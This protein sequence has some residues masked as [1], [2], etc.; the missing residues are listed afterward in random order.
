MV[1]RKI[2]MTG[3]RMGKT[4]VLPYQIVVGRRCGV[5]QIFN[6]YSITDPTDLM[7]PAII[8]PVLHANYQTGPHR[9]IT[10]ISPFLTVALTVAQPM[11][12]ST[13]LEFPDIGMRLGKTILP[14]SY[15]PFDRTLQIIRRTKQV[16]MVRHQ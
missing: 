3:I 1:E 7:H 13:R 12:K 16:Q 14:K 5:A 11:M 10:D 4:A 2:D 8:R 6:T 9:I 15:P